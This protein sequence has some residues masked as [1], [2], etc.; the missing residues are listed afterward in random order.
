MQRHWFP[1]SGWLTLVV[2]CIGLFV[3]PAAA[4]E[5][6]LDRPGEREFVR[7]LA[8]L[9]SA[10][11]EQQIRTL[12]DKLLT[13]KA[14]PIIVVTIESMAKHNGEGLRI[15]TFATLLFDQWGIGH[16][17][18]NDQAW[19]TGILLLI[20]KG[21]RKARIELGGGWG[22]RED[23][24][25]QQIMDQQIV[26][27]FK[28]GEFPQGIIAGVEALDKMARKLELPQAV[29]PPLTTT[30]ILIGVG[31]VGLAIFTI[32][33]LIRRGSSG[34]AWVFWAAVFAVIGYILYQMANSSSS[35]SGGFS[36][37]SFGG[38]SS[39]GGGASGSW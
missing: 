31:V 23:E 26:P 10:E 2:C 7:D 35:S 19:N 12:C 28:A 20:S 9:L 32:V 34:W 3:S 22:R 11:D 27:H 15:E 6:K 37:G 38:G 21:D 18:I 14:T 25:C 17:K 5:I 1:L 33:S 36:G 16:A 29:Q 30:Q 24:L 8:E 13:E 39:G 4:I